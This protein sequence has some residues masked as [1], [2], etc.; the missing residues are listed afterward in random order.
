[1]KADLF[2]FGFFCFAVTKETISETLSADF[3]EFLIELDREL[4][5]KWELDIVNGW[6]MI[7]L[8][9]WIGVIGLVW[10]ID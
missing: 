6:K 2:L 8:G 9:K 4:L 7:C 5:G 10:I 1:M 3:G